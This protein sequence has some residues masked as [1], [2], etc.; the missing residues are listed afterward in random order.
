M[1][2]KNS[3]PFA[4]G[5]LPFTSKEKTI[6][7]FQHGGQPGY[8]PR[9]WRKKMVSFHLFGKWLVIEMSCR[10]YVIDNCPSEIHTFDISM[11]YHST[12]AAWTLMMLFSKLLKFFILIFFFNERNLVKEN[13]EFSLNI[14]FLN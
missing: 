13:I 9:S 8:C 11:K 5:L 1:N 10:M 6:P 14:M 7:A 4:K 2:S 12:L 3:L